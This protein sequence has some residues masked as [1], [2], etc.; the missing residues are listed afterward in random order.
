M[1]KP[2]YR[3]IPRLIRP[4]GLRRW[5]AALGDAQFCAIK[6]P[7]ISCVG[8]SITQGAYANN[9]TS[10]I[11]SQFPYFRERGWVAQLRALFAKVYGDPGEGFI[12]PHTS[13]N[14]GFSIVAAFDNS[15]R[16]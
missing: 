4:T 14:T 8:D 15:R 3:P 16:W 13:G 5:R 1:Q 9:A 2:T 11:S 12:Y 6:Q 10:A 7:V